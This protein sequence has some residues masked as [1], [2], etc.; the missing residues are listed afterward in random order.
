[1]QSVFLEFI[2]LHAN[3]AVI[4]SLPGEATNGSDGGGSPHYTT[5]IIRDIICLTLVP[6]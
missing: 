1:M 4:I 2:P 6:A 5:R 3:H